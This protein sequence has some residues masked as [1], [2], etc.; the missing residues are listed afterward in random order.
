[1][2]GD[3]NKKE[4]WAKMVWNIWAN[5]NKTDYTEKQ[6]FMGLQILYRFILSL[7]NIDQER[8]DWSQLIWFSFLC[9]LEKSKDCDKSQNSL[10]KL[11]G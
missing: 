3:M 9:S 2:E 8:N 6:H 10:L 7:N 4:W 1:M 11:L 5:L